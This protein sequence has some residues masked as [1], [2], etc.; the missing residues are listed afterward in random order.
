MTF[1]SIQFESPTP[2][3]RWGKETDAPFLVPLIQQLGY[4]LTPEEILERIK[5]YTS[6]PDYA[7][8]VAEVNKQIVGLLALHLLIPFHDA[9]LTARVVSLVVDQAARRQ[10]VASHLLKKAESYA[11]DKKCS[12]I[13]L[14]TDQRRKTLG[15]HQ[16]YITTGYTTDHS[17][18]YFC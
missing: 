14:T 1:N 3:I 13:E 11:K 2:I 4:S 5:L 18:L 12:I 9:H 17:K 6:H 8:F 7:L 16:L 15:A 10:K